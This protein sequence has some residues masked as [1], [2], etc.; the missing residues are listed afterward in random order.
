MGAGSGNGGHRV[1]LVKHLVFGNHLAGRR[2]VGGNI[3]SRYYGAD[4]RRGLGLAGVYGLDPGMGVRA[5]QHLGEEQ[6]GGV[7]VGPI[8]GS[9]SDLV[10]AVVT[11]RPGSDDL[12]VGIGQYDVGCHVNPPRAEFG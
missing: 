10:G 7:E 6:T 4:A 9:T 8:L 3:L 11:H 1:T 5:A 12:V 2:A